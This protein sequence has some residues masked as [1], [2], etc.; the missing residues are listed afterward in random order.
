MEET[1]IVADEDFKKLQT[2]AELIALTERTKSEKART[3]N[4]LDLVDATDGFAKIGDKWPVSEETFR[5]L[6]NANFI[7]KF[8]KSVVST[9]KFATEIDKKF[10]EALEERLT[11]GP[12][13][14]S[15]T[16]KRL[17]KVTSEIVTELLKG[18]TPTQYVEVKK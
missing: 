2:L 4:L 16:S 7:L 12:Y 9:S 10:V 8:L 15:F 3:G 11:V 13:A 1:H 14:R 17:D 6:Q 18:K 5:A